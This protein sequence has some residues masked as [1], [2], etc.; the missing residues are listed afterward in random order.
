MGFTFNNLFDDTVK[1]S[2]NDELFSKNL[3]NN[4]GDSL[5]KQNDNSSESD[6][7]LFAPDNK[8]DEDDK[9]IVAGWKILIV[10]DEK[11]V[12]NVT[13]IA[14]KNFQFKGKTID[15]LS[16]YSYSEA[17][18]LLNENPDI[19][20]IL[21]DI[22]MEKDNTGFELLQ[23]IRNQL[24]NKYVRIIIRTGQPGKIPENEILKNYEANDYKLKTDYTNEQ[25]INT[26]KIGLRTFDNINELEISK[27]K[28]KQIV[29]ERS[30]EL[31]NKSKELIKIRK[32]I[33]KGTNSKASFFYS[34]SHEIR[35]PLNGILGM[36]Q[37]LY[38][39]NLTKEQQELIKNI[40]NSGEQLLRVINN[41]LDYS[42]MESKS[43][44]LE[45]NTIQ[46]KKCLQEVIKKLSKNIEQKGLRINFDIA[47][48]IPEILYGDGARIKQI[49]FQ[50][51]DNAIKFTNKGSIFISVIKSDNNN[52]DS[53]N[54]DE[55]KT[56]K[57]QFSIKD[58]G[59]GINPAIK[60]HIFSSLTLYD[61]S[62]LKFFKGPG[63][64]LEL[65]KELIKLMNGDI[66]IEET[67]DKGTTISFN[68]QLK[69]D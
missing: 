28:L 47:K 64:G 61:M 37:L 18:D 19:A 56:C 55:E 35:N 6:I 3:I 66:W 49:I 67:S 59:I 46:I 27:K 45:I 60:D 16:A 44:K 30:K 13:K 21:L 54:M 51:L 12:H 7:V 33:E 58:T 4:D 40:F 11:D 57:V 1:S 53:T 15:I 5:F 24:K 65:C 43:L 42:K 63:L 25:L 2:D 26:V 34:M 31:I 17:V 29:N 10:D 41:I 36:A 14:L 9:I 68:I 23:Y 32:Q 22:V 38:D 50:L 52:L 62:I 20:L 48:E 39:T 8:N 69:V